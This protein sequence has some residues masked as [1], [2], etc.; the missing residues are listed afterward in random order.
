MHSRQL[1]IR[2]L[3]TSENTCWVGL[4]VLGFC[5]QDMVWKDSD[6]GDDVSLAVLV[7]G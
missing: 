4:K 6:L 5:V 7:D 3:Q 1:H 2:R